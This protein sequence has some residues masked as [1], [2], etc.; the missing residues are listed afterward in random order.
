MLVQIADRMEPSR[1]DSSGASDAAVL[2]RAVPEVIDVAAIQVRQAR[3]ADMRSVEPLIRSFAA[4]NLMLPR[5]PDQLARTFREFMVAADG[6]GRVIGCGALRVYTEGL[7]EICSLAVDRPYQAHGVGRRIVESLVTEARGLELDTVFALTLRP[8]FFGKLGFRIVAKEEFPLKVWA[9]CRNCP[10]LHACD[11][12]AVAL[13]L[14][15]TGQ[16]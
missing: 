12:I 14:R 1:S 15:E 5:S 2:L 8:E 9:D 10:K 7:A 6:E 11:E 3:I 13:D 16:A 4:D